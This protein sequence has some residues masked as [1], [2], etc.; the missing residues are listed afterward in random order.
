MA[1]TKVQAARRGQLVRREV[2]A[3]QRV[4]RREVDRALVEERARTEQQE[5]L[6]DASPKRKTRPGEWEAAVGKSPVNAGAR[7]D[8]TWLA[9]GSPKGAREPGAGLVVD[10][11]PPAEDSAPIGTP[12]LGVT[13]SAPGGSSQPL[14]LQAAAAASPAWSAAAAPPAEQDGWA[15]AARRMAARRMQAG[16][17]RVA[18]R[19][20]LLTALD[21]ALRIQRV[22]RGQLGRQ[23]AAEEAELAAA[24]AAAEEAMEAALKVGRHSAPTAGISHSG[25]FAAQSVFFV[26]F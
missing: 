26:L 5:R 8:R 7:G 20:A 2:R 11:P 6:S 10:I 23:A 4:E 18:A 9:A 3:V 14:V 16:W 24:V 15:V 21:A 25:P 13:P 17:R 22:R 1:A 19:R 12:G